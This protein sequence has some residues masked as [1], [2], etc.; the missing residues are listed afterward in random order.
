IWGRMDVGRNKGFEQGSTTNINGWYHWINSGE[1]QMQSWWPLDGTNFVQMY[2]DAGIWQEFDIAPYRPCKVSAYL[3]SNAGDS[4]R[5]GKEAFVA[6]E[7]YDE[8]GNQIGDTIES[9][10]LTTNTPGDSWVLYAAE[11][12]APSN[13]ARARRLIVIEGSGDGSVFVDDYQQSPALVVKDHGTAKAAIFLYSAGDILPDG[14]DDGEMDILP[15]QWRY[16]I[17]GAVVKEYFGIEPAV[18]VLGT[19]AY[20]CLAEYRTCAD[21]TTLWQIKNYLYDRFATNG[22]GGPDLT[23]TIS[24]PL[25]SNMTIRA[26]EQGRVIETNSDG[27]IELTLEPDGQEILHVYPTMTNELVCQMG[28]A[29]SVIHPMGGDYKNPIVNVKFDTLGQSGLYLVVAFMEVGDNGDGVTNEVYEKVVV[30][31]TGYGTTNIYIYIP[32]A[33]QNDTDY[34]STPDG[35][36]YQFAVWLEDGSSNQVTEAASLLTQLEWGVRPT[37]NLPET[38]NR[39]VSTNFSLEWEELYEHLYWQ[40]CPMERNDSFPTR[41]AVYRSLKTE[42]QYTGHLDRVNAVCDWL[43]SL[44]YESG[45]QLDIEFDNV[46]VSQA[47]GS[48]GPTVAFADDMESG[49]NGWTAE[50]LWH[51]S[52]ARADS[53]THSWVYNDGTDYDT[54]I[55]NSGGL[56]TPWI[57]LSNG[58]SA[59]VTF[60]SW[61]KTEDTGTSWDKKLLLVS[62]DGSTWTQV[63]QVSGASE[64]WTTETCDLSA[65][66]GQQIKLKFLFDSVDGVYNTF[67]GWYVD[68]VEVVVWESSE[69]VLFSDDMESGTNNWTAEGLWHQSTARADSPT[70]SWVYNDGTDYDTGVRNS[71]ALT[72][73]WIDLSAV[74]SATLS[75]ESWYR[76]EDTGTTWDRKVVYVTTD[77]TNWTQVLQVSGPDQQWTSW[78]CD[79]T[80]YCG[81]QVKIKFFLDSLDSLYNAYEGWYVDDV[82]VKTVAGLGGDIFFEDVE[83]GTN[84]WVAG[85]LWHVASDLSSSPS[86][87]WAYNDGVD[88]DTGVA[89]SGSLVSPWIDLTPAAGATLTFKSWYE[90]E[91]MGTTWDR[92]LVY[93][94]T[95]GTNWTQILQVSGPNKQWV[96]QTYDLNA[97]A[98]EKIKLKFYFDT[99]D[100]VYNGY[101]GWYVDDISVTMVGGGILFFE[102]FAG[103]ELST[104]WTRIA[105]AANWDVSGD[106]VRAWRIGN[107]DNILAAGDP[108]W[109]NYTVS[110]DIRYNTQDPYLNDAELYVRFVDRDNFVKVL[111]QNFY[112]FWRLK[113]VVRVDTNNALQYWVHSFSKTNRP[114]EGTWYNLAVD[115]D[116]TNYTVRFDGEEVGSFS[117]PATNFAHATSRVGIG[118]SA[119]QLGIWEPQ[120][121]YFFIDDDEYSFSGNT[122]HPLDLDWGYLQTFFGTLVLPSVYVMNDAEASNVVTWLYGG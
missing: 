46:V 112:G 77:G 91:D 12:V 58:V 121:G 20:L 119:D 106:I 118:S 120:K 74:A 101:A 22:V 45:N 71:G 99:G 7:W 32:D 49:T 88:Y 75:F 60:K 44:G 79:L 1:I 98:G 25:F 57:N 113:Y 13:A 27:T 105:G 51:Q 18:E 97:Y 6:L 31:V 19:N 23:F 82:E 38:I 72:T 92:K 90:T 73:P 65:Y 21:T 28:D 5:N 93:V 114:V 69:T 2:G 3:R 26:Y 48:G 53:P 39:G 104:N 117:V 100:A 76:T 89:N 29:Y 102:S 30:P 15:W 86:H 70:H 122:G 42:A 66:A 41:I 17:F 36:Q 103:S 107:D 10:H 50:G 84:N 61:Y 87:S 67:E 9:T 24:S 16:D 85:G 94:T 37:S 56:V 33:N 55:A 110:A 59:S 68:G 80:P 83:S 52:T 116:G 35:G 109:S 8:D 96:T 62:T 63:K 111:I 4:L 81:G 40:H 78:S 95:D 47:G 54:G 64:Q 108:A 14:D 34:I 115:V 43:E 11:G